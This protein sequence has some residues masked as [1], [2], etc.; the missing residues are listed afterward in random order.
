MWCFCSL[1]CDDIRMLEI[2]DINKWLEDTRKPKEERR[3]IILKIARNNLRVTNGEWKK[4]FWIKLV[5]EYQCAGQ[6]ATVNEGR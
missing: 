3:D 1:A 4:L 5:F 2:E 6:V